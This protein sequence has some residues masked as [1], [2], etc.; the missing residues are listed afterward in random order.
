MRE[1]K[2]KSEM[3]IRHLINSINFQ[4]KNGEFR[5]GL[6]EEYWVELLIRIRKISWDERLIELH[7]PKFYNEYVKTGIL[8]KKI[9]YNNGIPI[10]WEIDENIK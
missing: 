8:E 2:K 1:I 3:D 10:N 7:N 6:I 4:L 9:I 5:K